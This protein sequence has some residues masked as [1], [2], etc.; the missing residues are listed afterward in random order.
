MNALQKVQLRMSEVRER[1]NVLGDEDKPTDDQLEEMRKLGSEY[2]GLEVR[3]RSLL[4]ADDGADDADGA[5]QGGDDGDEGDDDAPDAEERERRKL[6]GAVEL[7]AYLA[8]AVEGRDLDGAEREFN[9]AL[10]VRGAG[11]QVPWEALAPPVEERADTAT[12]LSGDIVSRNLQPILGRVFERSI[13]AFL[14]VQMPMASVGA[15]YYPVFSTGVTAEMKAEAAAVDA[16]AATFVVTNIAP[17]RLTARYLF[18]VEDLATVEGL[19]PALRSDLSMAMSDQL[20]R[21]ILTGDGTAPNLAGLFDAD[22]GLANPADPTGEADVA[23]YIDLLTSQVDGINAYATDDVR[24]L[25]GPKTLGHAA[26]KFI[27]GTDTSALA[28]LRMLSGGVRVSNRVPAVK[29][30]GGK[31]TQEVLAM[32]MNGVAVA[33]M[34]PTLSLVRDIYSGAAKGQVALTAIALYGFKIVRDNGFQRL[35]VRIQA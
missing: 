31:D 20:D 2:G 13:A 11:V 28:Y 16:D 22:S 26:K 14:G 7:R 19:E 34:W 12:N 4:T 21:Q 27:T 18:S 9:A 8:A 17:T 3:Y 23:G 30:V 1:L 6:A 33:P 35:Q 24:L 10:G 32:R 29:K 25:I 5:D 15:R